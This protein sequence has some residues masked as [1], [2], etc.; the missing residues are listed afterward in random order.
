MTVTA[1]KSRISRFVQ[2]WSLILISLAASSTLVFASCGYFQDE[3]GHRKLLPP[4]I[5]DQFPTSITG[6]PQNVWVGNEFQIV[7]DEHLHYCVL[8][9]VDAPRPGNSF[10][11]ESRRALSD[12]IMN[13]QVRLI[14]YAR[15][16][17]QRAIVR[18]YVDDLDVNL[19]MILQ[20]YA[21]WDGSQFQG[22]DAFAAAQRLARMERRGLWGVADSID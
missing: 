14:S 1:F 19:E 3:T 7:D 11:E 9:G 15:D 13:R 2:G 10:Y 8:R 22:S 18:A 21:R 12:L 6:R 17:W 4:P 16:S 20:G 5:P